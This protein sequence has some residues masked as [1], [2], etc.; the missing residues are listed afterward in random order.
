MRKRLK[1]DLKRARKTNKAKQSVFKNKNGTYFKIHCLLHD[2]L[3]T[4]CFTMTLCRQFKRNIFT[5]GVGFQALQCELPGASIIVNNW[6]A[7]R[8]QSSLLST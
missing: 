8:N 6:Q 1:L 4:I 2:M 5:V 3:D 7:L